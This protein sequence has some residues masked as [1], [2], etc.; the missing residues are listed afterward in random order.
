MSAH[1]ELDFPDWEA[2]RLRKAAQADGVSLEA[3]VLRLV[4]RLLGTG[5]VEP[6]L[7]DERSLL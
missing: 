4:G 5:D 6:G 1:V 3:E 2:D 7:P